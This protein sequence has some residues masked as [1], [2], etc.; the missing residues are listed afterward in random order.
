MGALGVLLGCSRGGLGVLFGGR[1]WGY[2]DALGF[3]FCISWVFFW[4]SLG[5]L[6]GLLGAPLLFFQGSQN[7]LLVVQSWHKGTK[8]NRNQRFS[9]CAQGRGAK[10]IAR[11]AAHL[12]NQRGEGQEALSQRVHGAVSRRLKKRVKTGGGHFLSFI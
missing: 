9:G 2:W 4:C 11:Q 1:F 8:R 10:F 6:G 7:A 12:Q 5:A 3:A